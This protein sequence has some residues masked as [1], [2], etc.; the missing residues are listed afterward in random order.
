MRDNR[1]LGPAGL[2][3]SQGDGTAPLGFA[4]AVAAGL[5]TATLSTHVAARDSAVPASP[6]VGAG[7]SPLSLSLDQQRATVTFATALSPKNHLPCTWG[8]S[9][10][11]SRGT[12]GTSSGAMSFPGNAVS[13]QH[14]L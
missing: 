14:R 2:F 12:W 1:D 9:A 5:S 11:A 13:S 10:G 8:G 6:A 3:A 7:L 4:Q